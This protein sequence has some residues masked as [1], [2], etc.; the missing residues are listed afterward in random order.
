MTQDHPEFKYITGFAGYIDFNTTFTIQ[1]DFAQV[2]AA[3]QPRE[4]AR[5]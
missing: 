1:D 2:V 3:F 5:K 4:A